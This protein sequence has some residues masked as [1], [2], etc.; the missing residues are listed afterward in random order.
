[1]HP[2]WVFV[3]DCGDSALT[4][5]LALLTLAFLLLRRQFRPA[6]LWLAAI[7]GCAAVMAVLKL[8]FGACG[9]RIAAGGIVSPSGHA[10]MS[11]AIYGGLALLVG[12][13]LPAAAR[14]ALYA[15][16]AA[17][18]AAIAA[19]RLMLHDHDAAELALGLSVGALAVAG[20]AAGL[21]RLGPPP[22]PLRGFLL[23]SALLFVALH[24]TRWMIEPVLHRLAEMLRV[25]LPG[26][27]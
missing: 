21:R 9:H 26:C 18:V 15:A 2:I 22:L 13:Q 24:G 11:A 3:T 23:C 8:L 14:R 27:H 25:A 19:S 12:A 5:P 17:A 1:M 10:A 6:L 20:F 4:L 16:T 7:A